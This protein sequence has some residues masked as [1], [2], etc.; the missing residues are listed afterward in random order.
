MYK[1]I[2]YVC[3]N[4]YGFT[5]KTLKIQIKKYSVIKTAMS[6]TVACVI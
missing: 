3:N 5:W 6:Y 1:Y 4:I 2:N